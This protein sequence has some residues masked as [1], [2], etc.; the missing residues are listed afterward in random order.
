MKLTTPQTKQYG[1]LR[2]KQAVGP[3]S[4]GDSKQLETLVSAMAKPEPKKAR[5]KSTTLALDKSAK[6]ATQAKK[7]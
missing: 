6:P 7:K 1:D 4:A 5:K 3:L 2:A